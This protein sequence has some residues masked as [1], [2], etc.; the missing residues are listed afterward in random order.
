MSRKQLILAVCFLG[1]S[2]V[3][4]AQKAE[5]KIVAPKEGA[6]VR[7]RLFVEGTSSIPNA[8]VWIVV[9]PIDV[10]DYWVQP[11]VSVRKNGEWA[12]SAYVG[13]AGNLDVGRQFELVAIAN[14]KGDLKEGQVLG[15]WPEAE[16]R[17]DIVMVI[18]K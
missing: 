9:H 5:V 7:E 8:A 15:N 12:V 17:S 2:L 3:S 13:R 11:R 4:K 10:S 14:P 6:Q 1:L 18:R 16:A